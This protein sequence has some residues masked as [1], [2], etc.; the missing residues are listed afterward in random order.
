MAVAYIDLD[1]FKR[2]NDRHGH[3]AGDEALV[4]VAAALVL[5]VRQTDTVARL[6][7]DEFAILMDRIPDR[8]VADRIV[9]NLTPLRRLPGE[10]EIGFSAGI[11]MYPD[12]AGAADTL[13]AAA[14]QLMYM[15]K[16]ARRLAIVA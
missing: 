9:M 7:G 12:D 1:H 4:N 15:Q 13:L 16:R 6:A 11:A 14:D 2:I 5:G 3:A 10:P 8:A